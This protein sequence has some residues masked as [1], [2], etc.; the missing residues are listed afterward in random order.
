MTA[1]NKQPGRHKIEKLLPW[2]GTGTLSRRDADRVEQALAGDR[3]LARRYELGRGLINRDCSAIAKLLANDVRGL[4][5]L[6]QAIF[7]RRRHQLEMLTASLSA[8]AH[9]DLRAPFLL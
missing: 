3:E 7:F 8:N 1:T 4:R 6:P 9:G 2:H 5:R